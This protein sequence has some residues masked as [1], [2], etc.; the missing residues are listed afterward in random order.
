MLRAALFTS[1]ALTVALQSEAR[2]QA[3]EIAPLA[4]DVEEEGELVLAAIA[5]PN[6]APVVSGLAQSADIPDAIQVRAGLPQPSLILGRI[7]AGQEAAF[8]IETLL[9]A[10]VE[11]LAFDLDDL[12]AREALRSENPDLFQQLVSEG[13]LDPPAALLNRQLQ[14]ELARM[15]CYR[16]TIDGLWGGGSRGS[17][18][19]YFDQVANVTRTDFDPSNDMFRSILI[20]GDVECAIATPVAAPAPAPRANTGTTGTTQRATTRQTA[21]AATQPST[22]APSVEPGIS[23]SGSGLFR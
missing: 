3:F 12:A 16:S 22:S 8:G 11:E 19:A 1:L 6:T 14:I 2:A 18:R 9:P 13:H 5:A 21:P 4:I 15:N 17:A 23:I 20:N 10:T 7:S